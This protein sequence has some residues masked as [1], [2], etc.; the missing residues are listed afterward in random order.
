MDF[1]GPVNGKM[2]LIVIDAHSR[3]IQAYC[4]ES[5]TSSVVIELSR[6]LFSQFGIPKVL[7]TDNGPFF[8]SEEFEIFLAKNGVKHITSAPYHPAIN[9]LA[10]RAVK[11]GL[12]KETQ[13]SMRTRLAKILMAYPSTPQSTTG[14]LPAQLLLGRRI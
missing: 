5:A 8:V 3:W 9:G 7:V 6:V 14:M 4:T 2:I 10:K 1:A 12:K 11:Q 13:G